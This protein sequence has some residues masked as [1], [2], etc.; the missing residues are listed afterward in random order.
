MCSAASGLSLIPGYPW[1]SDASRCWPRT[2]RGVPSEVLKQGGPTNQGASAAIACVLGVGGPVPRLHDK[3]NGWLHGQPPTRIPLGGASIN[4]ETNLVLETANP[5]R[6]SHEGG[7]CPPA[8]TVLSS[9]TGRR[10]NMD[11]RGTYDPS[12]RT[13]PSE[14]F[15]LSV[16]RR[17]PTCGRPAPGR[18][19]ARQLD[20]FHKNTRHRSRRRDVRP[21]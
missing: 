18:D 6:P 17:G 13:A 19:V 5:G 1:F 8:A 3:K 4:A 14:L 16:R 15:D 21:W 7:L 20:I 10:R 12:L 9:T 11:L 2:R